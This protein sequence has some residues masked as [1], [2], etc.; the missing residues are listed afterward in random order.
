M[1]DQGH[2][3]SGQTWSPAAHLQ[4]PSQAS[5]S[6]TSVGRCRCRPVRYC[7][8]LGTVVPAELRH[9]SC[10]CGILARLR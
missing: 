1:V 6:L 4:G 8:D 5:L 3:R 2:N 10:N 7:Q 9:Y